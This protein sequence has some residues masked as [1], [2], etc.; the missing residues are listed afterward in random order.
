MN[1]P[2]VLIAG[3]AMFVILSTSAA[4][5]TITGDPDALDAYDALESQY[6]TLWKR[7]LGQVTLTDYAEQTVAGQNFTFTFSPV[8]LS[9]GADGTFRL[10]ARGDYTWFP[11]SA[12]GPDEFVTWDIDGLVSGIDSPYLGSP[13]ITEFG[14]NDVEW[15]D[16]FTISGTLLTG[17]TSDSAVTI[18]VD[19]EDAVNMGYGSSQFMEVELTYVPE[20][21]TVL[22]LGLGGLAVLRK[23]RA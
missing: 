4:T 12:S 2:N 9:D 22:L 7:A 13:V 19:L 23:R 20:P 11:G 17:I 18:S 1:T 21:G 16:T 5:G 15:Q 8:P 6:G 14:A 3:L 10:H